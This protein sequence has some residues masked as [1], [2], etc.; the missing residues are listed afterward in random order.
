MLRLQRAIRDEVS[1]MASCPSSQRISLRATHGAVAIALCGVLVGCAS[2]GST[3]TRGPKLDPFTESISNTSLTFDMVPVAGGTVE[4]PAADGGTVQIDVDSFWIAPV[5]LTWDIYDAFHYRLDRARTLESTAAD[6]VTRPSKP[7]LPPDRG[8]GH[9]GYPA[10][11]ISY[12]AATN[13]CT[14]LSHK[15]GRTYRLPTEAEW[16]HACK[17]GAIDES[18]IDAYAWYWDNADYKTHPVGTKQADAI[19]LYDM[20]GNA[21]EWCTTAAGE[22]VTLGG[23]FNEDPEDLGPAWRVLDQASWNDSDPQIPKGMWWLADANFVGFRLVC[24]PDG[25]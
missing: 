17:L 1:T 9:A 25:K 22:A 21:A 4:M 20:Y 12:H 11:S 6:A 13:F 23:S 24:D 10:I 15:T 19:G 2:T 14:W 8:F 18:G 16:L 7:Y 3:T 5:E